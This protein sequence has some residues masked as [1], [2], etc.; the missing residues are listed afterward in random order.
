MSIQRHFDK[1]HDKIK[2]GRQDK[3]YKTAR[4]RDD[5]ITAAVK[6]SFKDAGYPVIADF[7]QGSLA[8]SLGVVPL[9]GDRDID[10]ALVIDADSAPGNPVEPKRNALS[11][12]EN[13]GFKNATIKKP[14]V[15]ADYASEDVHIDFP[16]YKK[17]G[18]QH[19]LAVGKKGSDE[20]NREWSD[21][22]PWG[23]IDFINDTSVHGNSAREKHDQF[24]RLVRYLKRWRDRQFSEDVARKIFSIGLSVMAK[25]QFRPAF[26]TEGFRQDLTAL[27]QTVEAI[28]NGGY[29]QGVAGDRYRVRVILPVQPWR[30]IFHGG[31]ANTATQFRN[32]LNTLQAKLLEAEG[33]DD[34]RKQCKILN[35]LFGDDFEVP[36]AP[37]QEAS[38]T[39]K[40]VY[41]TAGVVGTSQGA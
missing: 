11:V 6:A 40:A 41:P 1:F 24:R 19:Y 33:L 36:P 5:S 34:I 13:R 22:D 35:K 27:R 14:C 28:L 20:N 38:N 9:T 25:E 32:K 4:E 18:S 21:A 17:S 31:N 37:A 12:L 39:H 7:I 16:I 30:D 10:R 23:L 26:T 15:T 2:L 29:F 3:D 8:M